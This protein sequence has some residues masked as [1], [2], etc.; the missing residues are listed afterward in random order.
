MRL[1][2]VMLAATA[3][4][5]F[6]ACGGDDGGGGNGGGGGE[7]GESASGDGESESGG[8]GGSDGGGG[9]SDEDAI[10]QTIDDYANAL[11]DGDA[12]AACDTLADKA[13][14]ELASL[15]KGDCEAAFDRFLPQLPESEVRKARNLDTSKM[16]VKVEGNRGTVTGPAFDRP[17]PMV[18]T[19][20]EWKI[21]SFTSGG[22]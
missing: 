16:K 20:G 2:L 13:K 7:S 3:L 22:G 9:G 10:K 5:A 21:A 11:A 12:G 17:A 4:L 8:G 1:M 19:G 15:Y 18:K 14:R 6:G